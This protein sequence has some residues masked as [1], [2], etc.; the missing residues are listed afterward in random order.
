M[1]QD[2]YDGCRQSWKY[3][4]ATSFPPIFMAR[5]AEEATIE[6]E[7][8]HQA[9]EILHSQQSLNSAIPLPIS[10]SVDSD[11]NEWIDLCLNPLPPGM[12]IH[13]EIDLESKRYFLV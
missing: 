5:M 11:D 10:M 9:M 4:G 2:W 8:V 13:Q 7:F 12:D 1:Q 3:T 6:Y